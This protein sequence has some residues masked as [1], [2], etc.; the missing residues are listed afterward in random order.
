[1]VVYRG[2]ESKESEL[3]SHHD[4][5]LVLLISTGKSQ[6]YL[7]FDQVNAF[8]PDEAV[9]PEKI[10]SLLVALE[11]Q[12][13]SLLDR[14]PDPIDGPPTPVPVPKRDEPTTSAPIE[15]GRRPDSYVFGTN[16]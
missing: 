8:L 14:A 10:D 4:K 7:T 6:G 12:G 2:R 11:E 1:M 16:G 3:M 13:I 5:E 15:C 9:D